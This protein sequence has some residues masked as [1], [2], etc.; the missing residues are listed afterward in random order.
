MSSAGPGIAP[1]SCIFVTNM[2]HAFLLLEVC[3]RDVTMVTREEE[4][5]GTYY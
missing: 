1:R 5:E 2:V 3:S 4:K